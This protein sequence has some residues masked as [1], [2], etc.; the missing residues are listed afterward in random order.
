MKILRIC[1]LALCGLVA[2]SVPVTAAESNYPEMMLILDASGSMWGKVGGEAKIEAA[3]KVFAEIIPSIPAEVKVGLTAYGHNR[4][5]D[6]ADIE[7]LVPLGGD[8]QAI[9]QMIN[10]LQPK[11]KT[12]IADSIKM[13]SETLKAKENETMIVLVSDGEETC[14]P[15]PCGVVRQLKASGIK[16]VLHV[17]GFDVNNMQRDQLTCLAEAGGG[18]Y[19][20]AADSQ[21]L[22][23]SLQQ[24]RKTVEVKVQQAKTA[25]RSMATGLGKLQI[26]IPEKGR[27]SVNAFKLIRLEDEKIIKTISEPPAES[28]HPLPAGTYR[29]IA[30]FANV[31]NKP[32]SEVSFGEWTVIGGATTVI[33]LGI[34]TIN[35]TPEL[36]RM[37]T[38]AVIITSKENP[39]FNLAVAYNDNDYYLYK[40]KPLP[41]GTYDL[42]V[43]YKK[44]YLYLTEETPI[45]LVPDVVIPAGGEGAATIDSGIRLKK[46]AAGGLDGFEL[47]SVEENWGPLRVV[48][49]KN[50]DYPLWMEYGVPPGTY[51]LQGYLEGMT[52]PMPLVEG[53]QISAGELLE[54]DTGL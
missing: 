40:P 53:L 27:V 25:T 16:F 42:N 2:L 49:A 10:S 18:D 38:G 52:E 3:R 1:C 33:D 4:K 32:D 36:A 46:P 39:S 7:T 17:V 22:L 8:R 26:S 48:K 11:G 6:C 54:V 44:S 24:V 28:I 29:L 9:L 43:H 23:S 21:A 31:N 5:G 14:N 30:G 47:I 19:Y 35:I 15:D 50:G 37:A 45:L 41:A 13:V 34:L 20:S 12:P 51:R